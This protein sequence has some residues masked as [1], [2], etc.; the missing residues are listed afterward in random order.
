M[1][2]L[3]KNLITKDAMLGYIRHG[4]TTVATLLVAKG[5]VD[6]GQAEI[7]VGGLIGIIGVGWSA[8]DKALAKSK[9]E[10]AVAAPAGKAE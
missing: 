1:F 6:A 3:L 10:K 9:L 2:G 5:V 4:L 8:V 7:L